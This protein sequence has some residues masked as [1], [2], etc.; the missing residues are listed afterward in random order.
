MFLLWRKGI[1]AGGGMLRVLMCLSSPEWAQDISAGCR[2]A[3][4]KPCE[5]PPIGFVL[6]KKF[7]RYQGDL[8][9][10]AFYPHASF[11]MTVLKKKVPACSFK[12]TVLEKV[13]RN[14][15]PLGPEEMIEIKLK[16]VPSETDLSPSCFIKS[17]YFYGVR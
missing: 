2:S 9:L 4:S 13:R 1:F 11:K 6:F 5:R 3:A 15:H 7:V 12:M 17:P 14:E 16:C 10:R 8:S